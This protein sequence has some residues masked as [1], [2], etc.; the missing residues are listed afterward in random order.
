MIG[1][2]RVQRVPPLIIDFSLKL[3]YDDDG[4]SE[5]FITNST[6][7]VSNTNTM[8]VSH[9]NTLYKHELIQIP[10]RR[11]SAV[12]RVD[13][14]KFSHASPRAMSSRTHAHTHNEL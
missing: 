8:H 12:R 10:Q 11:W 9:A 14:G 6:M 2:N 1:Y 3:D 13:N 7:M 4:G 5:A